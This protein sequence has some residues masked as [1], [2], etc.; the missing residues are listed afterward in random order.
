MTNLQ[1]LISKEKSDGYSSRRYL[2]TESY[3]DFMHQMVRSSVH[4]PE[5]IGGYV[6]AAVRRPKLLMFPKP[7]YLMVL[8]CDSH[9]GMTDATDEL[10]RRGIAKY[11]VE[12]SPGHFWVICDYIADHKRTIREMETIPGV[13][14]KYINCCRQ[15][16]TIVLRAYPKI[17]GVPVFPDPLP[18][19]KKVDH[20]SS[21]IRSF[22]SH[23][24]SPDM[25]R[26]VENIK[27]NSVVMS[28]PFTL[29]QSKDEPETDICDV[30]E[31]GLMEEE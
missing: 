19:P 6:W 28:Q 21:W 24:L 18:I 30:I 10:Y 26:V 25:T 17:C 23:W 14:G 13:D 29:T 8:D 5:N 22:R 20:F 1:Y 12:S 3:G 4:N 11:V 16:N 7:L 9:Q 15:N 31:A 2:S 27:R